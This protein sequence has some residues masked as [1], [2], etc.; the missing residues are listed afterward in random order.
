MFGRQ[1]PF[2]PIQVGEINESEESQ[3]NSFIQFMSSPPQR[4]PPPPP[5][6]PAP[7]PLPPPPPP[8][9]PHLTKLMKKLY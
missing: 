1:V 2:T 6:R 9:L 3:L 5:Q 8:T 7:P 4:I